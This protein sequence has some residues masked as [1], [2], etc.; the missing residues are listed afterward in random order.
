MTR[1]DD[2][3][4]ANAPR[5]FVIPGAGRFRALPEQ[6]AAGVAEDCHALRLIPKLAVDT[7]SSN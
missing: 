7:G 6:R 5:L 4:K 3:R 1:A 2:M